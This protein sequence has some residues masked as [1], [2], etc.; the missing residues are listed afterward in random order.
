MD[1][2]RAAAMAAYARRP[3]L[4][5]PQAS[6]SATD[7]TGSLVFAGTCIACHTIDGDGGEDGPDLSRMGR[8]HDRAWLRRWITNTTAVKPDAEMP[9]FGDELTPEQIDAVAAFLA[10]RK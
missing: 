6:P 1:E 2:L 5:G 4:R 8:D 9:A 3:L 7:R 10:E